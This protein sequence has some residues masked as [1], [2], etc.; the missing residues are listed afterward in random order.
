MQ[1]DQKQ[2]GKTMKKSLA[3][4]LCVML[5]ALCAC[6]AGAQAKYTA[7]PYEATVPG[8]WET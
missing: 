5:L 7:G 4:L 3:M 6:G 8:L 2:G 1:A